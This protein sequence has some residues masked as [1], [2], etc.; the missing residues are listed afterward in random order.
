M[1]IA[2]DRLQADKVLFM[3]DKNGLNIKI[4]INTES[5]K[6]W[7]QFIMQIFKLCQD[8]QFLEIF[9]SFTEKN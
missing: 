5:G 3:I 4:S 8:R 7:T 2:N 6:R 1:I 9:F